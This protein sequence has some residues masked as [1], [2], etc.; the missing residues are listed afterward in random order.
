MQLAILRLQKQGITIDADATPAE[1]KIAALQAQIKAL[2]DE[3]D[4]SGGGFSVPDFPGGM[5]GGIA[6]GLAALSPGF[7]GAATGLGLLGGTGYLA[8]SGIAKA[9]EASH[10]A[11]QNVGMTSQQ[12]AAQQFSD[13]VQVQQ[14]QQGVAQASE[15]SAQ[16]QITSAQSIEQ[17]QMNL[18][19]TER[20]AAA[21][22]VQAIQAV[23]QAQQQVQQST[24]NLGEA[25]YNLGQAYVSAREAI[26]QEND[27]L[28]DA[29]L[30]VKSASLAVQ[31]AEY[32][33]LL[34]NQNAYS[35]D[36]DREQAA[37][38]V[39]QA[40]Q[41]VT[42]ATASES[43][44][45]TA[46]NLANS[47]GVDGSQVVIQAKQALLAA[48]D[49]LTDSLQSYKDA[50]VN[51]TNVELNNAE[52]VKQAQ[53]Q[54][55]SAQEQAAYQ[56]KMDAQSVAIAQQNVTNTIKEQQ[57]QWASMMSTANSSANQFAL[58]MSKLTP[59]GRAFVNVFLGLEPAFRTLESIAQNTVL[60]GMTIWLQ[61]IKSLLPSIESGVGRMGAA[62]S[63]AFGAF[64]KQMQTPAFAKVLDGLISNGIRFT[65]IVLPAFAGFIREL[66]VVG[67]KKGAV[68]GLANLLAGLADGLTGLE[69]GLAPFTS[70][71]SSVFS[72]LGSALAAIGGPLGQVIGA[73]ASALAPALSALLPGFRALTGALGQGLAAALVGVGPLLGVL[74]QAVSK[75]AVAL[76]PVLP[77]LGQMIAQLA[78]ALVP[79]L[80]SLMP[81]ITGFADIL[82]A[83]LRAN[84][85]LTSA[86]LGFILP[87]LARLVTGTGKVIDVIGRAVAALLGLSTGGLAPVAKAFGEFTS[88]ALDELSTDFGTGF[89]QIGDVAD[90][91]WHD[92]LDPVWQGI[93]AGAQRLYSSGIAPVI[94]DIKTDIA[95]LENAALWMWHN[96]FDPVWQGIESGARTFVSGFGTVWGK[97]E[98]VFKT[99]VNFLIST[100]YDDGIAKLWDSVVKAIGLGSLKLPVI[101]ALAHG[102]VV[103]GWSPGRDNHL[104]AVSGGEGILTPQ[105]TRAVGGKPTIDAL[106]KAYPPSSAA[107][108]G[109][110]AVAKMAVKLPLKELR[111]H[112]VE[113]PAEHVAT[114]G[115][116]AGG[117]LV[118]GW[119]SHA[120]SD[121]GHAVSGAIGGA[122]DI[123]KMV[124]A[125][126]K[127]NTAAFTNAAAKMIGTGAAGDLGKIMTGIPK[128]LITDL[129]RKLSGSVSGGGGSLPGGSSGATGSLPANW[130]PI[131][132]FLASHGATKY[133]AAGIT[134][135]IDAESGGDPEILETGG[136]GG[137]GLIQWT[138]YPPGYITGNAQADL[139]TQLNAILSWGGGLGIVNRATSPSNAALLYQDYY[140]KPAN[141]SAS[142]PQRMSS[143]N[144]VYHAMGWGSFD[145]GG[146][147]TGPPNL[148]GQPEA[149]LTPDQ[150][151]AFL[152]L[153]QQMTSGQSGGGTRP[154]VTVN[155]VGTQMPNAEQ[156]AEIE[157]RL[158][159]A[160]GGA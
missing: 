66:A 27:A 32:N 12:L 100:V 50:Q 151:V 112:T 82:A 58:D 149:V 22:Q 78:T 87:P 15:Q 3:E 79:V 155:F 59:A 139:M 67:S 160:V 132:S 17:A 91:L 2:Q 49:S 21:A 95:G 64:G 103:P 86:E 125:I 53:M 34:V 62:I 157:R 92:V 97:L 145:S 28:A 99:P 75:I 42:D 109:H 29:K 51:V 138:P 101:P 147:M 110:D 142:L 77:Q 23:G 96:V 94:Q 123:A 118:P 153:V 16:D 70:S 124:A 73:L 89:R 85:R 76:A 141:L 18:A 114:A 13:S 117:G 57:L 45:Q 44:A 150:S 104:A 72:T 37:L 154:P 7:A 39:A 43:D 98:S 47:Q 83:G 46:A 61:G 69:K 159:M 108:G 6:T 11:S 131:A 38:A 122:L 36:L 74:G 127:G 130:K 121:A 107:P 35:T 146:W 14:A 68:D 1:M 134:G 19:S 126:A 4:E 63:G 135:N 52:Q 71:L 41:Q 31:Q 140:E 102:G 55:A 116:F 26:V 128:A 148:T 136:G 105:A 8:F 30:N 20:N 158:A 80:Q 33:E 88:G 65:D 115:M 113:R 120:A 152:R 143:A 9:L 40:K 25:Q 129:A 93:S 24:Y 156:M 48:Q 144:A 56:Q 133:A 81:L 5:I 90:W 137:G 54:V 60:P 10:E 84:L 119:L 111:K 106:N